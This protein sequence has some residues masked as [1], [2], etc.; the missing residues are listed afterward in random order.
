MDTLSLSVL[1]Y[2]IAPECQS[3]QNAHAPRCLE[4][5]R[6]TVNLSAFLSIS[7]HY[8]APKAIHLL[9]RYL[10]TAYYVLGC[11]EARKQATYW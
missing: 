11:R 8:H 6:Y 2:K 10:L 1:I 5:S 9:S 4:L 7:I 3:C